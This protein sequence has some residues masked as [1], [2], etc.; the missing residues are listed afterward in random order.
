MRWSG[1]QGL[2]LKWNVISI[3][4]FTAWCLIGQITTGG[5]VPRNHLGG[6]FMFPVLC[7]NILPWNVT[8]R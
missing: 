3:R 5:F 4:C 8:D 2:S 7:V 6:G 1:K